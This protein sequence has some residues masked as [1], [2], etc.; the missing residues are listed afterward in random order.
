MTKK[1]FSILL[2]AAAFV[3]LVSTM[4]VFANPD[5]SVVVSDRTGFAEATLADDAIVQY[6]GDL[7]TTYGSAGSGVFNAFVRLQGNDK[8]TPNERGYNTDG[9]REFDTKA[10]AWTHSILL[11][12]VP[13]IEFGGQLYWEFFADINDSDSTPRISLDDFELYITDD[14][15]LTGYPFTGNADLLYDFSVGNNGDFILINDVNQ[16]SGR[17]D[18]R[19]LVPQDTFFPGDCSYGNP[20][21]TI[22]LVL[23]SVWGGKGGVYGFDGGFEEWK[24]KKYPILQVSKDINGAFDRPV[25]WTITKDFNAN[26]D[27][28]T[29]ESVTHEY[30]VSVD[31]IFGAP[32]NALVFGTIT[33]VGDDN[34]SVNATITDL[35]NSTP[36]TVAF[37]SVPQNT[38]LTYPIAAG[39]T[40][41]CLYGLELDAPEEGTNVARATFTVNGATLA[42]QGSAD[43]LVGDYVET[44]T[45]YPDINVTDTNGE[46]WLASAE[47][48]TWTYTRTFTC[49]DDEGTHINTATIT[50]TGQS[51]IAKVIVNCYAL[52]VTKTAD[53]FYSRYFEWEIT[54]SVTPASWDLFKGESGTS[55]YTVFLDQTG[56]HENDWQ[57]AGSITIANSHPTRDAELT[58][59]LDDAG[60]IAGDVDCLSMIVPAGGSLVCTYDTDAQDSVDD[61]PFGDTNTATATQQLYTFDENGADIPDGTLDYSGTHA[62]DF[63]EATVEL[64]DEEATVYDTFPGSPVSG[65]YSGD[66]SFTYSR[67]FICDGDKG[68]HDNTASYE[69]NDTPLT[70]SDDASVTV[71]CYK[72]S[73]TK[74][75]AESI[76]RKY[77]WMIDK[78]VN[79]EG[80]IPVPPGAGV[81]VNYEVTVDLLGDPIDGNWAV[82]GDITVSNAGNPIPATINSVTDAISDV[83]AVVVNC[84]GAGPYVIPADDSLVC[85]YSSL[86]PDATTRTN[87]ATATQQLYDFDKDEV[88]TPDG[89]VDYSGNETIDFSG[90]TINEVDGEVDVN[91]SY[92]DF[93]GTCTAGSAPCTFSY[94]RTITAPDAFCGTLTVDNTATFTTN[95]TG[96]TGSA[97][98][99]V[100]IKV[101]CEGC[102]P[103]F[104]QGGAGSKLWNEPNDPQWVYG[105]SNPFI[106]TTLFN[107]FFNTTTDLRLAGQTMFQIV[108][109][110]GGIA[111]SAE[112]AARDMVAAYLNEAAFPDTFPAASLAGLEALWYAAVGGGD[113]GLDAFHNKVSGW[114]DPNGGYCPLP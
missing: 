82:S 36:A 102:T 101:P 103:G 52:D 57:V 26:Y 5:Y 13:T 38:D 90:A 34:D 63:G 44:L 111:N 112:R 16:G 22:Y 79:N 106:H 54:K 28:F 14:P 30:E 60:G 105:G 61:N 99:S 100:I 40:V 110:E 53:E 43:I 29:G 37:C 8:K 92:A 107:D 113:A 62:I 46:A 10:G 33:I 47:P 50:E 51:D 18:L 104:W 64:V 2:L 1:R 97:S 4:S 74:T 55:E 35:F 56:F 15:N 94:S 68:K 67:T 41:T 11:S 96:A 71:N 95:N 109:N 24:V 91:D 69:T 89:T 7:N 84:G 66:K 59:V 78:V 42:F 58:Q 83:G 77:K 3:L 25:S 20:A 49:D 87:T 19:Y 114:N 73:V 6:I 85:S 88:A 76:T 21:C 31:P 45:G 17:G 39:A 108:S 65:T 23:Y 9:T 72:L 27:L 12:E 32:E 98:A 81:E 86:L 75:V 80:P 48:K 93:L 70:G